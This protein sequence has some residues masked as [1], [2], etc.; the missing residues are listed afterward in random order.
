MASFWGD[1]GYILGVAVGQRIQST[2]WLSAR[3]ERHHDAP[4]P[5]G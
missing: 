4:V 5:A 2:N 3:D 1:A